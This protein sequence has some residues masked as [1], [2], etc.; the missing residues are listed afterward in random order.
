MVR[1]WGVEALDLGRRGFQG[2]GAK[3]VGAV[4]GRD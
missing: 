1:V 2:S 3:G 4:S